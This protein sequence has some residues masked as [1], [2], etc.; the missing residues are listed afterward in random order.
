MALAHEPLPQGL[1][2]ITARGKELPPVWTEQYRV[3]A[4]LYLGGI[5]IARRRMC[6]LI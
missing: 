2:A 6:W 3:F 1:A 4:G 5:A